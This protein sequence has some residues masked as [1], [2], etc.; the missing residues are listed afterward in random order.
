NLDIGRRGIEDQYGNDAF[1]ALSMS[2]A[3]EDPG[4]CL[5]YGGI[6]KVKVNQAG[7]LRQ[8]GPG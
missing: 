8:A 7:P 4:S 3:M 2:N 1:I 5:T 6:R